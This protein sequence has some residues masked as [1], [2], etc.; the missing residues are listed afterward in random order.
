LN[1]RVSR[2]RSTAESPNALRLSCPMFFGFPPTANCGKDKEVL[3][4]D[5]DAGEP[6]TP[7]AKSPDTTWPQP[8]QFKRRKHSER[9]KNETSR[10]RRGGH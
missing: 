1:D 10:R 8:P 9:W 6:S 2:G 7:L 4:C 3:T 5:A